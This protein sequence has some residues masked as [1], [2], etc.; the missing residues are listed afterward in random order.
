MITVILQTNK[1][2]QF[3]RISTLLRL[4]LCVSAVNAIKPPGCYNYNAH[5]NLLWITHWRIYD[6]LLYIGEDDKIKRLFYTPV[7]SMM[8]GQW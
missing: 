6:S 1:C 3:V 2:T 5:I 8:M 7:R 4:L